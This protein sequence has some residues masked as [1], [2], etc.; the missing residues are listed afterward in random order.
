MKT[1]EIKIYRFSELSPSAQETAL[2]HFRE[3]PTLASDVADEIMASVRSFCKM[4]NIT[5]KNIYLDDSLFS[6]SY[7][8]LNNPHCEDGR[9][10][11]GEF[12]SSR[13]PKNDC[14]FTG[15]CWDETLLDSVRENL[16]NTSTDS[17]DLR[18]VIDNSLYAIC[19]AYQDEVLYR[20]G[21]E[22]LTELI[23]ANDYEF[24]IDGRIYG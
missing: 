21:D 22:A 5:L 9:E 14:P 24:T 19:R 6:A 1:V 17:D 3:D 20:Y 13:F 10:T 15:V 16:T 18:S 7:P 12:L 11:V 2:A 8:K 23:E 4:F